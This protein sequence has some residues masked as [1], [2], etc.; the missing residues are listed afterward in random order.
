M[1]SAWDQNLLLYPHWAQHVVA[2]SAKCTSFCKSAFTARDQHLLYFSHWPHH[3][4]AVFG[5]VHELVHNSTIRSARLVIFALGEPVFRDFQQS[6]QVCAKQR[7]QPYISTFCHFRT[8]C[9][10]FLPIFSKLDEFV[11]KSE[12]SPRSACFVISTLANHLLAKVNESVQRCEPEIRT[13]SHL[14]TGHTTF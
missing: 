7:F 8:G 5:K 1:F 3:F 2:F 11:Q 9:T 14:G 13:F 6:A 4:L 12:F 10:T